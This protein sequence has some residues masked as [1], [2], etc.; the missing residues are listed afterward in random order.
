MTGTISVFEVGPAGPGDL[1]AL[2]LTAAVA[3]R[4]TASIELFGEGDPFRVSDTLYSF[5][6]A[7]ANPVPEPGTLILLGSG[8]A[9]AI[10][11][12]RRRSS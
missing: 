12:I 2:L 4:G 3:G 7:A 11:R 1:G 6:P 9:V 8:V 5:S 10:R